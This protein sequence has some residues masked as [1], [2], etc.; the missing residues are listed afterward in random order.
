MSPS[1]PWPSVMRVRTSSMRLEPIRQKVHLPH[2][3]RCVN[4]RKKRA[5]STM[6]VSSS[7]TIRPPEPMIAPS[8]C[9]L[10]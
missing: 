4:S 7:I 9:R 6:Q 3:S 1:L 8:S 5:T 2:D 10:S